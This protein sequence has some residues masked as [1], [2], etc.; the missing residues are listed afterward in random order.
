MRVLQVNKFMHVHGGS[1]TVMFQ[2]SD[3]L[4]E[5]GHDVLFFSMQDTRNRPT[6][7]DGYFVSNVDFSQDVRRQGAERLKVPLI[8]GRL[9]Y[10]R[11]AA[12]NIE[13]LIRQT[14]PEIAHLHNIYHQLSPSILRPL[15]RHGIP[16]VMTLHD[17]KLICPNLMLFANGSICERC[18]GHRY[19]EAV[20]QKCVKGS[21]LRGALCAAEAYAHQASGVYERGVDL[22]LAPSRFMREKMIEFGMDAE[23]IVHLPNFL[24]LDRFQPR[25]EAGAYFTYAGRIERIKGIKTLLDAVTASDVA[26]SL[27]LRIAGDGDIRG[28]LESKAASAGLDSVRFL[29]RVPPEDMQE[30]IQ[31]AAFVV[32]PSE[33]YENAPM[34]ILEAFAYGKPV[35]AARIGGI[36]EMVTDGVTGL[37]FE[38]GN[39]ADLQRAIEHLITHPSLAVEMGQNARRV[40]E[41]KFGPERHYEALMKIYQ[42]A[43]DHRR[44]TMKIA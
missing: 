14:R 1:E 33:W 3:L 13:A 2:T 18:K 41:E 34:S 43:H 15:L 8:A 6:E 17:Y 25:Y 23:Q 27:E 29:G 5:H 4:R 12:Q 35:V 7:Q 37:L 39:V 26:Q 32:V 30:L 22:Y 40:V 36:P 11:E 42:R 38:S 19:Y 24:N 9:L 21:R 44:Q 20:L 10:S 31:G 28:D 16:T